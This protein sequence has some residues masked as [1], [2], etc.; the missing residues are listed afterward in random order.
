MIVGRYE[1]CPNIGTNSYHLELKLFAKSA[2]LTIDSSSILPLRA[3]SL[4]ASAP[5]SID[6]PESCIFFFLFYS[7]SLIPS[8][9]FCWSLIR[10]SGLSY[11]KWLQG[12][13]W[14]LFFFFLF[15]FAVCFRRLSCILGSFVVILFFYYYKINTLR[16][17]NEANEYEWMW[18]WKWSPVTY[19]NTIVYYN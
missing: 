16:S 10:G 6:E 11:W 3:G 19:N 5:F 17:K 4:Y 8:L 12:Q 2:S 7:F 15:S 18:M 9:L 14:H 1:A 13:C